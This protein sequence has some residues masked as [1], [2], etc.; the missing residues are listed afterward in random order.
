MIDDIEKIIRA[1]GNIMLNRENLIIKTKGT[2]E[3]IATSADYEVE[4]F[5]RKKLT[6]ILPGSSFIGE[7]DGGEIG[8]AHV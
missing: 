8:R 4:R 3:N 1:A 5:L 7:E 2:R 6:E